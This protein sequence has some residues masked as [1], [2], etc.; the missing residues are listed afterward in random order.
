M[1]ASHGKKLGSKKL[2]GGSECV[3]WGL[4]TWISLWGDLGGL[5]GHTSD[6]SRFRT[7]LFG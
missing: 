5:F 4:L 1:A 2:V 7:L 3:K 6:V